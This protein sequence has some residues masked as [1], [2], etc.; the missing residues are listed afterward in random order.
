[1]VPAPDPGHGGWESLPGDIAGRIADLVPLSGMLRQIAPWKRL[2]NRTMRVADLVGEG[3]DTWGWAVTAGLPRIPAVLAQAAATGSIDVLELVVRRGGYP[4]DHNAVV[5]I[6]VHET[7]S[8]FEKVQMLEFLYLSG[9]IPDA[10]D[11]CGWIAHEGNR[12][13]FRWATSSLRQ[14]TCDEWLDFAYVAG[15]RGHRGVLELCREHMLPGDRDDAM[16]NAWD[17]A[18]ETDDQAMIAWLND[19]W[20][21][22]RLDSPEDCVRQLA[23][24]AEA[25]ESGRIELEAFQSAQIRYLKMRA[26]QPSRA[27]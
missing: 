19:N 4:P 21:M 18:H 11:A 13:L 25:H 27:T 23:N 2:E 3:P 15:D 5:A 9:N 14:P 12:R 22:P 26:G 16:L 6:V 17:K 20:D 8:H 7:A 24:I 10:V 1:M